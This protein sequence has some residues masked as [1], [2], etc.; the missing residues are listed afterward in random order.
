MPTIQQL[1]DQLGTGWSLVSPKPIEDTTV[2]T[3][4]PQPGDLSP[5]KS[6][7]RG[8]GQYYVV[9]K[10]PDGHERALKLTADPASVQLQGKGGNAQVVRQSGVNDTVPDP[11]NPLKT[12]PN[13]AV[14]TG[15]LN[16]VEWNQAGPVQDVP[17]EPK[18]PSATANL[19]QVKDPKTGDIIGLRDPAT[20]STIPLPKDPAGTVTPVGD[21][22]YVIKPDGSSTLVTDS[23]GKPVAKTKDASQF[24]V[25][26]IGLVNYDPNTQQ[27]SV[28]IAAPKGVQASSLKP[29]VRNGKTYVP[30][31]GPN[32]EI[33]WK[34]TDL[35]ADVTYTVAQ[36]DPRSKYI[37]LLDNTG[38]AKYVEKAP[39]WTPPPSTQAGQALTPD[40]TSPFV[41]TIGDNGQPVF[42]ENKNRQSITEAQQALIQQL[43]VKVANGS[44]SEAQAKDLITSTT[45]A[46][47]AQANVQQAQNQQQ[48]TIQQGATGALGAIQQSAQAG[49]GML[50]NRV[51]NAQQ[52]LS[53]VLGLAG[54]GQRSGNM[55][56]GLMSAPPGLGEQL[57]QGAGAWATQLG[58]GE[59]VYNSAANLVRRADPNNGLGGDAAN[60]YGVLGQMLQKYR[61]LTGQPHP[62]EALANPQPQSGFT[63]PTTSAQPVPAQPQPAMPF[64]AIGNNPMLAAQQANQPQATPPWMGQLPTTL[65]TAGLPP[66]L[67]G[68]A[69]TAPATVAPP[70][71]T[72]TA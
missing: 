41:V 5:P 17:R 36:N 10:D 55:G 37:T 25:P 1:V 61:D 19:D 54:Q 70:A 44:M 65:G 57:V 24:N 12:I 34:E 58:G 26:G 2:V 9:V 66:W 39:D 48:Q 72:V 31:D 49:A 35:P 11:S 45:Q 29:E 33:V 51:T 23:S 7:N 62:A 67:G 47:T 40:T 43:G 27:A 56:G 68:P 52:M 18:Q 30:Y 14:Y 64:G 38:Q 4:Q 69:F 32:G 60:A 53:G 59:D 63:S 15:D 13:P 71:Q 42:T 16:K 20:G 28:L 46:M 22:F 8:T 50:Q 21:N 3:V 6:I